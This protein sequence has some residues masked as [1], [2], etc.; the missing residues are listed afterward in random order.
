MSINANYKCLVRKD[1]E[2]KMDND[3]KIT[4]ANF[5]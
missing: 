2:V 1:R 3:T 5:S 4:S